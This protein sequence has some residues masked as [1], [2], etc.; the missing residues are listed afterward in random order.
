MNSLS[1]R[2]CERSEAIQSLSAETVWIA[3]SQELLAMTERPSTG[4]IPGHA[5]R[6]PGISLHNLEV[7]DRTASRSVRNDAIRVRRIP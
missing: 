1:T 2:H 6:E 7:P 3:S 5:K 4:V